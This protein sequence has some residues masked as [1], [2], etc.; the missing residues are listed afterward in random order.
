MT[1]R[2]LADELEV[3]LRTIYRDLDELGAA[4]VPVYAERGA[5]GGY[6]LIDGYRTRLTGLSPDEAQSLFLSGLE[7][8]AAQLGLGTVLAA[9]QLK[10]MA[11]LPPELRS[12]AARIR[13]RFVLE[14]PGWFRRDEEVACL[15]TV[16][17]GVW[18][19]RRLDL[20]YD[21][22][23]GVVQRRVD[24]LGLVLKAGTWYLVARRDGL[25]RTYR[26]SRVRD[27][28]CLDERFERPTTFDLAR[29]WESASAAFEESLR[30]V[31]VD[32]L[33]RDDA[34]GDLRYAVGG[35]RL[36]AGPDAV[37]DRD[38]WVRVRYRASSVGQAHDDLLRLG[39]QAE[40]LGPPEL[41]A[42]LTATSAALARTYPSQPGP[43]VPGS[44]P[45]GRG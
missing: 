23:D 4:G 26:V 10:V 20:T 42:R 14:A 11:A 32:V 37:E 40:V 30:R 1:A 16:A 31:P 36:D 19:S 39:A 21:G 15:G 35:V 8:P 12:R 24:P 6:Q 33:V 2:E 28:T 27:A 38:G 25:F 43:D 3:S 9:A 7:G 5:A 22:P 41:R 44:P 45:P 18:E 13:E 29:H 17:E 34:L